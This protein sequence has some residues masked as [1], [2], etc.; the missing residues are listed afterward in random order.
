MLAAYGLS[1]PANTLSRSNL[2]SRNLFFGSMPD[3]A[4]R[5]IC[6]VGE[7]KGY[8]VTVE[9]SL[10][11]HETKIFTGDPMLTSSGCLSSLCSN[12]SVFNEPGRP[13]WL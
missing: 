5:M 4:C 11:S 9:H 6:E 7:N 13:E 1:E 12:V 10:H 8:N 3:T 2:L